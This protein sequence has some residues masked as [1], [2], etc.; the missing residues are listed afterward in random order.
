[1]KISQKQ[2]QLLAREIINQLKAKKIERVP[3]AIKNQINDF[4]E[5]RKELVKKKDAV[6]L[7]INN[8]DV[9]LYKITGKID[10]VY[11]G[12][13]A[14]Q[15]V[16]KLEEKFVPKQQDIEDEIILKSMF[17]NEDDMQKFVDTIVAK[18]SKKL[19]SKIL[20]N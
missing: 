10:R 2:A 1:M 16:Q 3:S 13:S 8:H 17:A 14:A 9:I 7:E 5:K 4:V 12:D 6:Q 19:Q 15:I 20:S 18:H 11:G